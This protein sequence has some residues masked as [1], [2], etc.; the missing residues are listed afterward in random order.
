ML[1]SS[2]W[3]CELKYFLMRQIKKEL[4]CHPPREDVSWNDTWHRTVIRDV[5][6]PP[7]EDV[8]WNKVSFKCCQTVCRHPPHEDVSWNAKQNYTMLD[9]LKSSSS[10]GCEL[11]CICIHHLQHK[12]SSSSSWGCELKYCKQNYSRS[13]EKVILLVR[14]WVE[15]I[16]RYT[17]RYQWQV[18][19]LVKMWVEI[20]L[21]TLPQIQL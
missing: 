19:L 6:H 9:N 1:S 5:R 4:C 17:E 7:R 18:I 13:R 20:R 8:S 14:M 10:W 11:K 12:S 2:S 16:T 21:Q 3:G 15:M